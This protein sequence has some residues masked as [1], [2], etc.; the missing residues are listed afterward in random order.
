[1]RRL[2]KAEQNIVNTKRERGQRRERERWGR[3]EPEEAGAKCAQR[4]TYSATFRQLIRF[5]LAA[6]QS[7]MSW[8]ND[9]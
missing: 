2:I 7:M 9:K 6:G 3:K 5:D 8:A 1:M 4:S